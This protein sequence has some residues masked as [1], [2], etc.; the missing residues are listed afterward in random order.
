MY[1]GI[2]LGTSNSAIVGIEEGKLR[3]F[4]TAE[5]MDVMPSAIM[6]DRRGGMF[7]GR[8]AYEHAAFSPENVQTRF[9]RLMGTSSELDFK[10]SDKKLTPEEAS[11]E[12][13]KALVAQAKMATGVVDVQGTV[14]TIP[15]AFNQMQSEATMRAAGIA[16][17]AEVA[18]LQEPI[19]AAMATIAASA[20]KSGQFL[21]YDLGGGTFDAAIVQS[22]SGNAT[23]IA[24]AG[25]N[26]L[27][28]TDF[29]R[30]IVNSIVRPWLLENFDLPENFQTAPGYDRLV[31]IANYRSELAKIALSSHESDRIF[32]DENQIGLK[33]RGGQEIYLDIE[34]ERVDLERLV[35]DQIEQ[36]VML[37]RTLIAE[38]GYQPSD[39]D[40]IIM[41][42]GPSRMPFVRERVSFELGLD[43]EL[44]VDPM[45]AVAM[46]AAIYAEGRDWTGVTPATKARR[47]LTANKIAE[48]QLDVDYEYVQRTADPQT[49]LRIKTRR[50]DG[51]MN[52]SAEV[53]T[54]VGWTS[55]KV[56]LKEIADIKGIPLHIGKNTL[57]VSVFDPKGELVSG[58]SSE[59]IIVRA[60]ATSDG[61]PLMHN[62][63]VKVASGGQ[64]LEV[65]TLKSIASKGTPTP[66]TGV[67][68]FRAS[69]TIRAGDGTALTI[70]LYEQVEGVDDPNLNLPIGLFSLQA[71]DLER[72]DIVRRGEDVFV[73]WSIDANG[74][75]DCTIEFPSI[76]QSYAIGYM[77]T[78]GHRNFDG[79][80]GSALALAAINK[81][82]A[83]IRSLDHALGASVAAEITRLNSRLEQHKTQLSLTNDADVRR[84]VVEDCRSMRQEVSK[85]R[86][87]PE[88]AKVVLLDEIEGFVDE[89]SS[90][91][92]S[93][94]DDSTRA[95]MSR[96]AAY[97]RSILEKNSG[98]S[99]DESKKSFN[100]LKSLA[101]GS[102]AKHP[103]F[104]IEY[105]EAISEDRTNAVDK[106]KHDDLVKQGEAAVKRQDFDDLK[107]VVSEIRQN[108]IRTADV[109]TGL[110][111][112]L[113]E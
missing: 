108:S 66:L 60:E 71:D 91:G 18:L 62:I 31:R 3:F 10:S 80:E 48:S 95:K 57:K 37:C 83:D 97:S 79:E 74:L 67:H 90:Y 32:A 58:L 73:N 23:V 42:G 38:N 96:L 63:A 85:I 89:I 106:R 19:A 94:F 105:F 75:M 1:F 59:L 16:G 25:I 112:G 22:I 44:N 8:K 17:M 84:S 4:K 86:N 78:A 7:V 55:G 5:G 11:S 64:G 39:L 51:P 41:I 103:G 53:G 9:K 27:G 29:D 109:G 30:A 93:V 68:K 2:D 20:N 88:N 43:L 52:H 40:R 102:I 56:E 65:N 47:S 45:T 76:S 82:E 92:S 12:V 110:I 6:I 100:E 49:R 36:T 50:T 111:S 81:A 101:Y 24:H 14:I 69:K 70:E 13:L 107:S 35:A 113:M 28:G 61:M 72:G 33:D 46:G 15:A 21:I 54:D 77:S 26:M 87:Q 99:I 98:I 104:W 34:L